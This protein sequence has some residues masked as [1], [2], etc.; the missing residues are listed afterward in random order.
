MGDTWAHSLVRVSHFC[1]S[2]EE[3]EART[4]AGQVM[5]SRNAQKFP[6]KRWAFGV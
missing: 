6:E 2:G 3:I 5:K 4:I 1:I